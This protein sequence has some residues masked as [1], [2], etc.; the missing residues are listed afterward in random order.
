MKKAVYFNVKMLQ[1]REGYLEEKHPYVRSYREET[2]K[3]LP[4]PQERKKQRA[5]SCRLPWLAKSL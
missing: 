2:Q 5:S 3:P 4:V 1:Y